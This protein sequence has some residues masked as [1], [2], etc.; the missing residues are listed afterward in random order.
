MKA[1]PSAIRS[2]AT[3]SGQSHSGVEY[4]RRGQSGDSVLSLPN[5]G[6]G[7]NR[8]PPITST[9]ATQG[10]ARTSTTSA[11]TISSIPAMRFTAGTPRNGIPP[12]SP[13]NLLLPSDTGYC[14]HQQAVVSYNW[15][16]R[17]NLFNEF[18][19]GIAYA[20]R[21]RASPSRSGFTN[22]LNLQDIQ[23]DIFFNALPDFSINNLTSFAKGRPGQ[24]ASWK[25]Q[26]IDNVTWIRGRH[27]IK[28][29]STSATCVPRPTWDSLPATTTETTIS[30]VTSPTLPGPIF[31]S[32]RP[33]A[34]RL[35]WWFRTM[36][37][38][39]RTIKPSCRTRSARLLKLTSMPA[40]A[41]SSIRAITMQD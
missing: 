3:L 10:L 29:D 11:S 22:S 35:R 38:A 8:P 24:G 1:S 17:P 25:R 34:R 4:Q 5:V 28:P 33:R 21:A 18:R 39:P 20:L 12:I 7:I 31:C 32:G 26:F 23:R 16:V 37:A 19:G 40:C 2:A 41:R 14:D 6:R 36:T 30:P 15:M 27:T 13:N 9:T